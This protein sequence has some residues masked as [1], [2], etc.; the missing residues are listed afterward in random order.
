[1]RG[2][3]ETLCALM[4]LAVATE[5]QARGRACLI[6]D[7]KPM[8]VVQLFFGKSIPGREP[9]TDTEWSKFAEETLSVSF[10]AGFTAYDAD[11]QWLDPATHQI[12]REKS[13]VVLV[14]VPTAKML[15]RKIDTVSTAY[16]AQF[17]QQSVGVIVESACAAF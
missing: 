13:K 5:V 12:V 3:R 10:P 15:A 14:A 6:A 8:T 17:H 7:Q 2:I 16:R 9:L 4:V 1:M 11:G